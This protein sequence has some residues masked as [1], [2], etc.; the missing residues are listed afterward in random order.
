M[1]GASP[2]YH[3]VPEAQLRSN[4]EGSLYRPPNLA[5]DGFIHCSATPESVLAVANDYYSNV[6]GRLL[7][8]CVDPARLQARLVFEA[9]APVAGAAHTQ[10]QT[11]ARFPHVYGPIELGAISGVGDLGTRGRY[12]W[13]RSFARLILDR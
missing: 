9:P 1:T 6:E 8:L 10:L 3:I 11:A 2:I 12:R 7:V 13:P 5:A 4:I